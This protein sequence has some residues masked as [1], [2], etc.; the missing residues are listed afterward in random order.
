MASGVIEQLIDM[1]G[2]EPWS[3]LVADETFGQPAD[4]KLLS[5]MGKLARKAGAAFL[6]AADPAALGSEEWEALRSTPQASYIG[7]A[8]PRVLLRLPYGK[9]NTGTEQFYFE[10]M[11]ESTHEAYLWG[12]PSFACATLIAET[13]SADGWDM[14]PGEFQELSGFPIHTYTED[15]EAKMKPC[16]E[17]WL[18]QR[19]VE[20]LLEQGIMPLIS[21]KNSDRIRVGRIQSIRIGAVPLAG[22]WS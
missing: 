4:L 15:G 22:R 12:N 16:A 13:F 5:H 19:D 20:L 11:P 18:T 9:Q 21:M 14:R 2:D 10:E 1:A 6:A 8:M 3:L 17:V 7:L